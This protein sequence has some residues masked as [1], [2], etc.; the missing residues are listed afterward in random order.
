MEENVTD[1]KPPLSY[2]ATVTVIGL[3]GGVFWG[4]IFQLFAYFNFTEVGPTFIIRSW[5]KAD[6][7]K[8]WMGVILS[9]V[10][11]SIISLLFAYLYSIL[12][13]K[14]NSYW[15]GVGYGLGLWA[16]IFLLL[17]PLF[18]G[19]KT[20]ME[21]STNTIITTVCLFLLFGL[22]I[23]Y[24]ISFE[25]YEEQLEKKARAEKNKAQV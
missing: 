23:G 10:C 8:G 4:A 9:L 2:G 18:P 5:I 3:F 13:R 21:L 19:M 12:F 16:L 6:F 25:Y 22:F 24:S 15:L 14:F 1:V 17:R 20:V 7:A 11:L